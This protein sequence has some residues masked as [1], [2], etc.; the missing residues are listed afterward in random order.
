MR[1]NSNKQN[2]KANEAPKTPEVNL[3]NPAE[4]TQESDPSTINA[5]GTMGSKDDNTLVGEKLPGSAPQPMG[6]TTS[7]ITRI[8]K[9]FNTGFGKLSSF[10]SPNKTS[11]TAPSSEPSNVQDV[12]IVPPTGEDTPHTLNAR[13]TMGSKDDTV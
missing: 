12:T 11:A 5:R 10:L 7:P 1:K 6:N 3:S 4:S 13:G 2:E 8:R 9:T